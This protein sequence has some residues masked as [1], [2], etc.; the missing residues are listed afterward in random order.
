MKRAA[1]RVSHYKEFFKSN[2]ISLSTSN[3]YS[4]EFAELENKSLM[5]LVYDY[6]TSVNR[7]LLDR[8]F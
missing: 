2:R 1:K 6:N 4:R 8:E 7:M 3:L 5:H